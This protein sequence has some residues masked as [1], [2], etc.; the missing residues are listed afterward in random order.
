MARSP[1]QLVVLPL[2]PSSDEDQLLVP[3]SVLAAWFGAPLQIVTT[4]PDALVHYR[5]LS[6]SLGILTEPP[7]SLDAGDPVSSIVDHLNA[8]G[9]SVC[10]EALSESG[11]AVARAS[12]QATFLVAKAERHRLS[13][14]PLAVE[15]TGEPGDLDALAA[16]ATWAIAL[17]LSIRLVADIATIDEAAVDSALERLTDMGIEVGVDRVRSHG[18][19]PLILVA[20]TRSSTAIVVPSDRLDEKGLT[21]R[22]VREGVSV[23]VAAGVVSDAR[24]ER[25]PP[26]A[27]GAPAADTTVDDRA[28]RAQQSPASGLAVL[29]PDECMRR[30]AGASVGR[31]AYID[32]G[33]PTVV[34]INYSV[35]DNEIFIRSLEGAKLQAARRNDVV[36][37][38]LDSLDHEHSVGWS[39]I[40]HGHLEVI[41]DPAAL[42]TAWANDP[43]PWTDHDAWQWLRLEPFSV[44]GRQV[45]GQVA[46]VEENE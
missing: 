5:A 18:L 12:D 6:G 31:I 35:K 8:T 1:V 41:A 40:V 4:D 22:A 37:L 34:P 9:P 36:C 33:W 14:G 44:S 39:V 45:L 19:Q 10:V 25:T 16:A 23:L 38:E 2:D 46:A 21:E 3:A 26:V 29:N 20:R 13:S 43:S 11:L 7:V 17:D 24:G 42:R 32:E 27:G 28:T 15:I 30:L